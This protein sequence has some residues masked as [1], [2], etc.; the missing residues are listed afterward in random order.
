[1]A[2]GKREA[3]TNLKLKLEGN[4]FAISAFWSQKLK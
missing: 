4:S 2:A 3:K 1:M